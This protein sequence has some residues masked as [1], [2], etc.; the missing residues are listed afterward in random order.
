MLFLLLSWTSPFPAPIR[1][2]HP[3]F[4][5]CS[6]G[7]IILK[8]A[9]RHFSPFQ[10]NLTAG[11]KHQAANQPVANQSPV[12]GVLFTCIYINMYL[13]HPQSG[14]YKSLTYFLDPVGVI[15]LVVCLASGFFLRSSW[16][17]VLALTK[18][19]R[20][21]SR[22]CCSSVRAQLFG[23]LCRA[24]LSWFLSFFTCKICSEKHLFG[25]TD[26]FKGPIWLNDIPLWYLHLCLQLRISKRFANTG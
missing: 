12:T 11:N 17:F 24:Q 1:L 20:P 10:W 8:T 25:C 22:H 6:L 18:Y 3:S 26:V 7:K 9:Y 13:K 23:T 19:C 5:W 2:I 4:P 16:A 21:Q 15:S 14:A